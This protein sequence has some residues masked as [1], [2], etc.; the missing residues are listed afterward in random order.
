MHQR[1]ELM[2][3]TIEVELL[4]D[5]ELSSGRFLPTKAVCRHAHLRITERQKN[6]VRLG[7]EGRKR[8]QRSDARQPEF[9]QRFSFPPLIHGRGDRFEG[10]DR[11][12]S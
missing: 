4:P 2:L 6:K 5:L 8:L 7:A 3:K 10:D 12:P 9:L 1:Y 11:E